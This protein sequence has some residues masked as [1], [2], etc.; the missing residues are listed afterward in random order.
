[1]FL[2]VLF[3]ALAVAAGYAV[4]RALRARLPR[5]AW[6]EISKPGRVIDLDGEKIHY[7]EQGTGPAL[8]FIHGFG[9]HTFSFRHQIPE[10]AKDHRVVAVDL[11]GFG[12]SGRPKRGD[13]THAAQAERVVKLM[14]ALGIE[15]ATLVG[16]S[17]GG[18]VAMRVAAMFPE[19]VEKL[20]LLASAS[21]DRVVFL[22]T[23]P[24]VK[25]LLVL[26][27]R[28]LARRILRASYYDRSKITPEV[29][30]GY[31]QP[32][33]IEGTA[34]A[35]IKMLNGMRREKP[36]AYER[37]TAPVLLVFAS[38]ERV[39]PRWMQE[40][41]RRRFPNA[42]TATVDRTGHLLQEERPEAVNAV[43][44]RFLGREAPG[45]EKAVDRAA[46]GI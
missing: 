1:M 25:P 4:V 6:E 30:E 15:R 19:R 11:L 16:H 42:E 37:I 31:S 34:D 23:L 40:R 3:L 45:W 12:Y 44:R 2:P 18:A 21:G 8:V 46:A 28:F 41:L 39:V 36:L 10:F 33:R 27:G 35:L 20:V 7:V 24:I 22:P 9:G 32:A 43:I 38:H 13:Y 26:A 5:Y 14:D 29:V 17:M